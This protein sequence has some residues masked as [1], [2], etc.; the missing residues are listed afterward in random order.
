VN[1]QE[2][3]VLAGPAGEAEVDGYG[4]G[5]VACL[6]LNLLKIFLI[7]GIIQLAKQRSIHP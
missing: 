1:K 6:L 4:A 3:S 2:N 5:D 7:H